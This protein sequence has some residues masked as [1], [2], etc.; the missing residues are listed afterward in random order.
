MDAGGKHE[1]RD[2]TEE[3]K[4]LA[5]FDKEESYLRELPW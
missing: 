1:A 5:T 3:Q 4:K 2:P